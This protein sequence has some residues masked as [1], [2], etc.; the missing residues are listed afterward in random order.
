M[1]IIYEEVTSESLY[2]GSRLVFH[3]EQLICFVIVACSCCLLST[4]DF[5]G[6]SV[7]LLIFMIKMKT[8]LDHRPLL[9]HFC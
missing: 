1:A 8:V 4:A 2:L 3:L 9:V 5:T 7:L 6:K